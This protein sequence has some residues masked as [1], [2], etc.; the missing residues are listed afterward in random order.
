[1]S[2]G[3]RT[4]PIQPLVIRANEGDCVEI[5]F[6]NNATGGDYGVHIDGLPFETGSSGDAV[7]NN[8]P[9]SVARGVTTTYRYYVPED[10]DLEGT[11][12]IR[13]GARLPRRRSRTACSARSRSSPRARSGSSPTTPTRPTRRAASAPA[14]RP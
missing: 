14:G 1:M 7:G 12:Y 9:S 4:D 6:T 5:T 8:A 13:P 11:H 10:S 2:I 3:L